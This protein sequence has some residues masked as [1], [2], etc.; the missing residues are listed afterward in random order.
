[1]KAGG[2]TTPFFASPR[3]GIQKENRNDRCRTKT[4]S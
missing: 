3:R 2:Y 4:D 1:M